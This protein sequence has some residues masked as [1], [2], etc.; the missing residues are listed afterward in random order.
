MS[1]VKALAPEAS[2][3]II[4]A[5]HEMTLNTAELDSPVTCLYEAEFQGKGKNM[6]G[7]NVNVLQ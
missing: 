7:L 1:V 5:C 4:S 6:G 2:G 3:K